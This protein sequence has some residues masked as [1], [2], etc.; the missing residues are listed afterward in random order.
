MPRPKS[1][2]EFVIWGSKRD[3]NREEVSKVMRE[4][5]PEIANSVL[6]VTIGERLRRR[7]GIPPNIKG[8][9]PEPHY[10]DD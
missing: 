4:G 10:S 7:E 5:R 8:D 9:R 2:P 1:T 3:P 6:R